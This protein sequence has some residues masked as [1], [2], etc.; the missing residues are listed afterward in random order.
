MQKAFHHR[1][2]AH[3]RIGVA[4][5]TPIISFAFGAAAQA[6]LQPQ[7]AE[8][9]PGSPAP[10]GPYVGG[11]IGAS[12]NSGSYGAQGEVVSSID[13][14]GTAF[15]VYFGYRV[16][17]WFGVEIGYVGLPTSRVQATDVFGIN[18]IRSYSYDAVPISL[19]GFLPLSPNW[20]LTGR[21]GVIVNHETDRI[22]AD[23]RGRE[24]YCSSLPWTIGA[25]L[26]YA[27]PRGFGLRLDYDYY[28]FDD[29]VDSA[30][31]R[32]SALFLGLDYRF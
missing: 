23:R 30:R 21:L 13:R 29:D 31:A 2:R 26:R 8:V 15:K 17:P 27:L 7:Y 18:R 32:V 22:C 11:A 1:N 20:E 16:N 19:A 3:R 10:F 28:G 4:L 14:S 9:W 6:Q 24:Y 25:G 12:H 5:L